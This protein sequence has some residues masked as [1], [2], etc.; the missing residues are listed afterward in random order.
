MF[1]RPQLFRQAD[2]Y[3]LH[4]IADRA[5]E[6]AN[7]LRAAGFDATLLDGTFGYEDLNSD[8]RF[9]IATIRLPASLEKTKL[10]TFL[11]EHRS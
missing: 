2:C 10:R 5:K 6:M 7:D 4:V 3:H 9:E 11:R 8:Q 1:D